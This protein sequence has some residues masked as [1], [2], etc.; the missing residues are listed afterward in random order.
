MVRE[1]AVRKV[2][3]SLGAT[4]PKELA[5]RLRVEA[6]DRLL[7]VE[8]EAGILLT[9]YNP[10]TEEALAL[11]ARTAKRYRHALRALAR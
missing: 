11:A 9:P 3:G 7:A 10:V 2:G 1:V 6:G 5:S 4:L 8:T